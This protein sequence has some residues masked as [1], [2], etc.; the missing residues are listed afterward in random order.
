MLKYFNSFFA[1][2]RIWRFMQI[3]SIV[4][5]GYNLH[6]MFKPVFWENKK[7]CH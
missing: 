7:K 1:E 6:E 2:N 4:S 5:I 3:V